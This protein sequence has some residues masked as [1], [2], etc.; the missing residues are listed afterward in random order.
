MV[1]PSFLPCSLF[2][3]FEDKESGVAAALKRSRTVLEQEASKSRAVMVGVKAE[4]KL[5][6]FTAV[7]GK[8][9]PSF[10]TPQ[11]TPQSEPTILER[12]DTTVR[13]PMSGQPLKLKELIPVKFTLGD[14]ADPMG[15]HPFICPLSQESITNSVAA[16]VLRPS[17]MVI[18]VA[19]L[20]NCIEKEM[21]CPFTSKTLKPEDIV[22][23]RRA[24]TGFAASG[25][26]IV[27]KAAPAMTTS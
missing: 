10:W 20:T 17:G 25:A 4:G 22:R 16:A 11:E 21:I 6:S 7:E 1:S 8:A 9:M 27:K 12:P 24:S 3:E 5:G 18:S 13:C 2:Q 15:K 14:G 19:S 26:K 23:L